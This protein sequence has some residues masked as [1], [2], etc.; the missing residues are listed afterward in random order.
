VN[1]RVRPRQERRNPS[2][3]GGERFRPV[4]C[5][6]GN[7]I[8]EFL[9]IGDGQ[10]Q[11][12]ERPSGGLSEV[13]KEAPRLAIV[14]P[15]EARDRCLPVRGTSDEIDPETDGGPPRAAERKSKR[16][17]GGRMFYSAKGLQGFDHHL[18]RA[19]RIGRP[20]F[21]KNE[22]AQIANDECL[23]PLRIGS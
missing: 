22:R 5:N 10:P 11:L 4:S 3:K 14:G 17:W 12:G 19:L 2:R 21:S 13:K 6:W 8:A 15:K 16:K 1:R 18:D 23:R 7:Q 20:R 9:V